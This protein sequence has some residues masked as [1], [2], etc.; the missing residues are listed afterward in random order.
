MVYN[1]LANAVKFTPDGGSVLLAAQRT[2]RPAS[3]EFSVSD[4]GIGI[5]EKDLPRLF[6]PSSSWTAPWRGNMK[7]RGWACPWSSAWPN[8]MAARSA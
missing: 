4:T 1:L 3:F 7:A 2:R 8:C 5:A 6:P